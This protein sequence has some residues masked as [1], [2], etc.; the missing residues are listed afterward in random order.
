M[1][2]PFSEKHY[3]SLILHPKWTHASFLKFSWGVRSDMDQWTFRPC[4]VTIHLVDLALWIDT[5]STRDYV[6]FNIGHLGN[7]GSLTYGDLLNVD[8]FQNVVLN[9]HID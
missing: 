2:I 5:S 1:S 4:Y 8:T 3:S 9:N 7:I 6:T